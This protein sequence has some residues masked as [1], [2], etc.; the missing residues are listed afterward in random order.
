MDVVDNFPFHT[1]LI[2]TLETKM[3][4]KTI[5]DLIATDLRRRNEILVRRDD[6]LNSLW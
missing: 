1:T 3:D 2:L 6:V 5:E 4:D